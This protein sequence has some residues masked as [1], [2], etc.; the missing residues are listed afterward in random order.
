MLDWLPWR[1]AHRRRLMQTPLPDAWWRILERNLPPVERLDAADRERLGGLIQVFLD[2]K[3]FEGLGGQTVDDEVRVTVAG[4]ACLLLLGL[5][6]DR[7]YP[8]LD[9]IR[10]YPRTYAA[11]EVSHDG[12][13]AS[14]GDSHRLG[15][16]SRMGYVVL[17][18]DAARAGGRKNEGLNVVFHEFAHQLDTESGHANGAPILRAPADYGPWTRALSQAFSE[19]Q[20]D[21]ADH[22]RTVLRAYGATNPA[23]FF[24][25]ATEAFF[26]RP[27]ALKRS[28]PEVYEVLVR[29]YGQ[30]P[31]AGWGRSEG[32]E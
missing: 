2:D 4:Q 18:W 11:K 16:S 22:R 23:E 21:V 19:L 13:V 28:N 32:A 3:S 26:E 24:A 27:R 14:E 9:V 17:T 29:Y 7:P 25:V 30:D 10:I 6:V 15:E 12:F 5:E 1:K 31:V 20:E 8:D